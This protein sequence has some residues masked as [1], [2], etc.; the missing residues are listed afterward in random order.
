MD[1]FLAPTETRHTADNF[2]VALTIADYVGGTGRDLM[3]GVALGYTVQSP[4]VDHANFMTRGFD[5]TSQLAFSLNAAAGRLLGLSEQQIAHAIAM[6]AVSDASF[7]VVRAKSLSQ[8]KGLA[9]A[10][11]ALGAMNTLF[12]ACRGVQGPLQVIE[13]PNGID[14]LLHLRARIDWEKEGYEGVPESTIKK[15]NAMI[16]TQPSI[17][18]SNLRDRTNSTLPR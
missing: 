11:S 17:A 13:G 8:W 4:L 5:H 14:N 1:N 12:L 7:A 10:Q 18:W 6:A 3:L 15:Y 2:G 16:H 9:S